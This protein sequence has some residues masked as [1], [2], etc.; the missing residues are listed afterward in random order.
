MLEIG[1]RIEF[2]TP[3]VEEF[4]ASQKATV[5]PRYDQPWQVQMSVSVSESS[6][7]MNQLGHAGIEV[8]GPGEER[9]IE[10]GMAAGSA[11]DLGDFP[12]REALFTGGNDGEEDPP[13][14]FKEELPE[15]VGVRITY[16]PNTRIVRV[17]HN[18]QAG[19]AT[20]DWTHFQSYTID[21]SSAG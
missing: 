3:A 15:V 7:A 10:V 6:F 11:P 8:H 13:F 1:Q 19:E 4:W 9:L 2:T 12:F 17:Y 14:F 21:G 5:E 18:V 20:G 16:D